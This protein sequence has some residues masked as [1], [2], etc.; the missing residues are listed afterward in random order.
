MAVFGA[1]VEAF[2]GSVRETGRD[3]AFGSRVRAQLIGEDALRCSVRAL[4]Q[5]QEQQLGRLPAAA[6]LKELLGHDALL[7]D[8]APEPEAPA[9]DRV[10]DLAKM[11]DC[12][13]PRLSAPKTPR[14][15]GAELDHPPTQR[16]VGNLDA[17]LE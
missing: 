4:E 2:G 12:A 8:G 13:V 6:R 15:H 1:I 16:L 3:L 17:A 9:A 14:D 10:L 7:I 5:A 11:P